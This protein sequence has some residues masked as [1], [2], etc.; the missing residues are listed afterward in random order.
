MEGDETYNP[1]LLYRKEGK[2]SGTTNTITYTPI[3]LE[4]DFAD[5]LNDSEAMENQ[6]NKELGLYSP[7]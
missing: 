3:N 1:E 2:V 5:I 6:L 4:I 7:L